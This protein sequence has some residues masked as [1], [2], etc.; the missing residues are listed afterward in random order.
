MYNNAG[1]DKEALKLYVNQRQT[2][3]DAFFDDITLLDIDYSASFR[4][5]C[6]STEGVSAAVHE[7]TE[8]IGDGITLGYRA[9][10]SYLVS[11]W[12]VDTM[13][14][15][16]TGSL[17]QNRTLIQDAQIRNVFRRF[18]QSPGKAGGGLLDIELEELRK[19]LQGTS[20][21]HLSHLLESP[22][23]HQNRLFASEHSVEFLR[24]ASVP[25]A[26]AILLPQ[27]VESI[28]ENLVNSQHPKF[29]DL[30]VVRKM[31]ERAS[32]LGRFL[33]GRLAQA[34]NELSEADCLLLRDL[35]VV[36]RKSYV[37]EPIE[38]FKKLKK[39]KLDPSSSATDCPG[40]MQSI[41]SSRFV[42]H[43]SDLKDQRAKPQLTKHG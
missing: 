9:D 3:Q 30:A 21:K 6:A 42:H 15:L 11:P 28:I 8:L 23:V 12:M 32:V 16:K 39:R 18:A 1:V 40:E 24:A 31:A 38:A 5:S 10:L 34:G 29:E 2:F 19:S 26:A 41:L 17:H 22:R 13:A 14:P 25:Q 4:C 7:P 35:L 43:S 27:D 33:Q 36:A 20:A 37:E